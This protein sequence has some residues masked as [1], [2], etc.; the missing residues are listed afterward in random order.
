MDL[1]SGLARPP[2]YSDQ[3]P[4]IKYVDRNQV[5]QR[6]RAEGVSITEWAKEHGFN[7][8]SVYSV[9][10]GHTAGDRGQAHRIAVALGL[11]ASPPT[12]GTPLAAA[13]RLSDV[14][15]SE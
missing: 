1:K 12:N 7:R 5:R 8:D 10:R 11:K 4:G 6:F 9:L 14:H 15:Q 13:A 3:R 2:R